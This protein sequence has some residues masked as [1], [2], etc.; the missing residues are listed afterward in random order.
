[1]KILFIANH[2]NVGGISSYLLTL[3]GGLKQR[4]HEVY[5]ASGGGELMERLPEYG[6]GHITVPLKTK[7]ELSPGVFSSF[8]RLSREIAARNIDLIHSNSRTT[9]VLGS[10]LGRYS[11]RPHI[12]TC[13]GFFKPRFLRRLF[14]CW[15]QEV[16]AIS[17]EVKEHLVK[18]FRLRGDKI[19]VINNGI[20]TRN[21]GDFSCRERIRKGLGVEDKDFLVGIVARLSDV[22]GHKY[23]I[24]AVSRLK[25]EFPGIKLLIAGRGKMERLL[26][27]EADERGIGKD[28]IFLPSA[29]GCGNILSAMDVFV[30]PSLQEGLGLALMEAMAQ[31]LPAVGSPV[32]GIKTLIKNGSTG[33]LAGPADEEALA[34]A[35]ATLLRDKEMRLKLGANARR[36]IGDNFS[37][38]KM[39]FETEEVY[40][41]CLRNG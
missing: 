5:L 4:G 27:R 35:I 37:K 26:V 18:D 24:R 36:F 20:D 32:G 17:A 29:K 19:T 9:Q 6:I 7:K 13:H 25:K 41:R 14:P 16:I 40:A 10:W 8:F 15:G 2:L 11:G 31:G 30:M 21:F 12:F 33:L 22:K 38:E 34:E 23:L 39:V 1:M 28:V 3:G